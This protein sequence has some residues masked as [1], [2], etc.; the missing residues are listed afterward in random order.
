MPLARPEAKRTRDVQVISGRYLPQYGCIQIFV[1]TLRTGKTITLETEP[2]ETI[3]NVKAKIQDKEGIS[4]DQQRLL[5]RSKVL[6]DNCTLSDYNIEEQSTLLLTLTLRDDAMQIF[7]KTQDGKTITLET[8]PS[9]TIE[10]VKTKIQGKEGIPP[11]QQ[12]LLFC[13]EVLKDGHTLSDYNIQKKSLLHL[14][15]RLRGDTIKI[16]VKTLKGEIITLDTEPSDTIEI[17]KKKIQDKEGIPPDDQGLYFAGK[18]LE[19]GNTLSYY[20]LQEEYP[21][22]LI[23]RL[24]GDTMRIFVKTQTGQTI[25]LETDPWDAIETVKTKIQDKSGIRPENQSLYLGHQLLEDGHTLRDY[26]IGMA[27][28]LHLVPK[29]SRGGTMLIILKTLTGRTIALETVPSD[30]IANVKTKIQ[31]REGIP[32][33]QQRIIFVGKFLE[34]S[35]TLSD[36]N[37]NMLSTLHLVILEREH[38]IV[39][40]AP[41]QTITLDLKS[42]QTIATVK[43]LIQKKE[44]IPTARQCLIFAGTELEDSDTLTDY[45]IFSSSTIQLIL[46]ITV[47][48]RMPTRKLVTLEL[49]SSDTIRDV[50]DKIHVQEGISPDRQRLMSQ[51]EELEDSHSVGE[52][53]IQ[54]NSVL[55]LELDGE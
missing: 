5:F 16:F 13:R 45:G 31:D 43:R 49:K 14:I 50:K 7:V 23:L 20:N 27:S 6:K 10:N 11:D 55:H 33:D 44:K 28:T 47:F 3:E 52:C 17:V 54:N 38:I 4:P 22:Q 1:K 51:G 19:D 8:E 21:L 34:D 46:K 29:F 32:A 42:N 15:L 39:Q 24:P 41:G 25:K 12:R 18:E 53:N 36:Y 48:L 26:M 2:S 37:V 35:R 9:D 40:T 30:T